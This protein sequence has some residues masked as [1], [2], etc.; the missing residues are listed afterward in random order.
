MTTP[1]G[2][3]WDTRGEPVPDDGGNLIGMV[4]FAQDI[5]E[6]KKAEEDLKSSETRYR[7]LA[8]VTFEGIIF[9]DEGV[10]LQ[11]N[12]QFFRMFGY[13]PDELVGNQIM[14]KTLTPDSREI[15]KAKIAERST[16]S[17]VAVGLRKD[18]TTFPIE[19]R[20]RIREV[21]GK[22]IRATAIRDISML[23]NL[24]AQLLQAQKMEAIGTLAGGVAHD[25]N[26]LLQ[27]VLGYSEFMLQ[28]KKEGEPDYADLQKIYQAGKR[29]A[30]LVKN[31]L[32]FS[33]R[34]DTHYLPIDL[35]QEITAV[36]G[37]LSRTIPKTI[38]INLHLGGNVEY[39]KGRP[40]SDRPSLDESRCKRKRRNAGWRN[41][42]H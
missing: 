42:D 11:A 38:N 36:R 32:T 2:R 27:T 20:A 7:Q 29:G 24:E 31:L 5:T 17:Y 25:F 35:N 37:L 28:R 9:H 26:N 19:V 10:L 8:D 23:K 12:D 3:V 30:D 21:E 18:G 40:V 4:E 1:D 33:R 22:Q 39:N 14:E 13:E 34:V 16:E 15:V 41:I 6:R